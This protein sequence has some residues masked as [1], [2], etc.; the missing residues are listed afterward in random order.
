MTLPKPDIGPTGMELRTGP[1]GNNPH[2]FLRISAPENSVWSTILFF[3][4]KQGL[5]LL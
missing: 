4:E 5:A 3:P 2:S 1:T